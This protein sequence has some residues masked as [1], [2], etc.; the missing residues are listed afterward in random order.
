[1]MFK[2]K[3]KNESEAL[4]LFDGLKL[5]TQYCGRKEKRLWTLIIKGFLVYLICA[6]CIGSIL[7]AAGTPYSAALLHVVLFLS[8]IGFSCLYYRKLV[9]N[10][11]GLLVLV[12]LFV[13]AVQ[14]YPYIN[15]G[16]YA[17]LNDL[18]EH[19]SDYFGMTGIRV[20]AERINN[21]RAAATISMAYLGIIGCIILNMLL[22]RKM[23]YACAAGL[24]LC[25]LL[26]PIYIKR[27]PDVF[28]GGMLLL[29]LALTFVWHRSGHFEKQDTDAEYQV[30][31]KHNIR[32]VYYK[33]AL[34]YF[35]LQTAAWVM[36]IITAVVLV[37]PKETYLEE[38]KISDLKL[39][40]R[41]TVENLVLLGLSGFINRYESTG[42]MNS[43]R[44]G[45][46]SSVNLDY[47]TDLKVRM[48]PYTYQTFY[49][50]FFTGGD[51]LPYGNIWRSAPQE[52]NQP[53]EALQLRQ[54]FRDG[55][56]TSAKG[57]AEIENISAI[58]GPY[59]PYYSTDTGTAGLYQETVS[60]TYYP[61]LS[62][63]T[64]PITQEIDM[65]YWL[66]IPQDNYEVIAAFCEEAGFSGSREEIIA[67]VKAYYQKEIPYTLRPGATPRNRDFINYFL[68]HN[69]KGYCAHFASAATLI[70]RYLGIPARYVEG[71]AV[72][73]DEQL[74][75]RLVQDAVYEDYYEGYSELGETA[76]VE[77]EVT[78]AD[79]HAWVEVYDENLGWVIVDVTPYST[80]EETRRVDFW[81]MFL[82]FLGGEE[83]AENEAGQEM[84]EA[85][86]FDFKPY[87]RVV[88]LT[89]LV[90]AAAAGLFLL[91]WQMLRVIRYCRSCLNDK[92]I[93]SYQNYLHKKAGKYRQLKEKL[94][95]R[96]QISYLVEAGLLSE[97]HQEQVIHILEKAGFSNQSIT[98]QEFRF[99]KTKLFGRIQRSKK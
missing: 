97:M 70:F 59:L 87:R 8:A 89:L 12:L 10:I 32:F 42:G 72:S 48:T 20:F 5:D 77:V 99:V 36:V 7:S 86:E 69:R 47:N 35:L 3:K 91:L 22:V 2:K 58:I 57:I 46:V 1:M 94:N 98:P 82:N 50:K 63:N 83:E 31:K 28:Y 53:K 33:K 6:G 23:R 15:S 45:G 44:L 14:L 61:R 52:Q 16:F 66:N 19:A 79:A 4:V 78:D 73:Y 74:E 71:Y 85:G 60:Y 41:G 21:R 88:V 49:L 25:L 84:Q 95:Y 37:C 39:S 80:E 9:E 62:A 13:L 76:L 55:Y 81:S 38:Q 27:E 65:E 92:L 56:E 75:G 90:T 51:Y 29:G 40:T 34:A 18:N 54:A 24:S 43:G 64:L 68:E 17:V 30:D 26:F 93:M 11:G 96:E 67:Q